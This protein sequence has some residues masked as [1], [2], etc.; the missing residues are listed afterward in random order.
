MTHRQQHGERPGHA[1]R[2]PEG[3]DVVDA[4][5]AKAQQAARVGPAEDGEGMG[6]R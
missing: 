1:H 6:V 5:G 4:S 2:D 3:G